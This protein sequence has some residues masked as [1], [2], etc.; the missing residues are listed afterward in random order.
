MFT[1][2][3]AT[4]GKVKKIQKNKGFILTVETKKNFIKKI[5]PGSSIAVD[6]VCLTVTK[7]FG[8]SLV[9]ELMPETV[10]LS[11]AN[12]YK[13][14]SIVNLE[15]PMRVGA[16][17][18]GHFVAGHVDGIGTVNK[19]KKEKESIVLTIKPPTKLLKYLAHKG[20][21]AINGVSLTLINTKNKSATF[22]VSLVSYTLEHTNLS[23]LKIGG[24]VNIEVDLLARYLEKLNLC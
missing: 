20:S 9:F 5:K 11:I 19:V 14:G 17:L 8:N 7:I 23:E 10:R 3:I 16:E 18:G 2:I 15:H 12:E 4:T 22:D 21:V 13:I 24:K 1:G 6:G